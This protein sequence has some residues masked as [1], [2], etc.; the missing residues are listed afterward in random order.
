MIEVAVGDINLC[1]IVRRRL[2]TPGVAPSGALPPP[3]GRAQ[4]SVAR[5]R[6]GVV[7]PLVTIDLTEFGR[8]FG[9]CSKKEGECFRTVNG[10]ERF[11]GLRRKS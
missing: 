3:P 2:V 1:I 8:T 4:R 9:E 7:R 6:V 10:A 5:S 11:E